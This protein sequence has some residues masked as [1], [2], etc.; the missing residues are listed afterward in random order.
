MALLDS[1]IVRWTL[2]R[3]EME[4]R[5][6]PGRARG[7]PE[8]LEEPMVPKTV[9]RRAG[10][11]PTDRSTWNGSRSPPRPSAPARSGVGSASTPRPASASGHLPAGIACSGPIPGL[12]PRGNRGCCAGPPARPC[13][14]TPAGSTPAC[15]SSYRPGTPGTRPW[16]CCA[17]SPSATTDKTSG[18]TSRRTTPRHCRSCRTNARRWARTSPPA[19]CTRT[20]HRPEC[21][22]RSGITFLC[23]ASATLAMRTKLSGSSSPP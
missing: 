5:C 10:L 4:L 2:F 8:G 21:T 1:M 16:P 19:P 23:D 12:R 3:P 20:R 18:H 14:G 7:R 9:T 15:S 17:D 11:R 13:G 6:D 22:W